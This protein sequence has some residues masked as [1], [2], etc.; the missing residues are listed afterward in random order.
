MLD[1]QG[2]EQAVDQP[3]AFFT[4]H[5]REILQPPLDGGQLF[6]VRYAE[7]VPIRL[8]ALE[9]YEE[10]RV[11]IWHLSDD[12]RDKLLAGLQQIFQRHG[13]LGH[14]REAACKLLLD[15]EPRGRERLRH[16]PAMR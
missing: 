7:E 8:A 4:V 15:I 13:L 10:P 14:A 9:G 5:F 12:L 6:S 3:L 2:L 1:I 11:L 16:G